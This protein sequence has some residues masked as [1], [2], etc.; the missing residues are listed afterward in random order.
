MFI[1][2]PLVLIFHRLPLRK[3]TEHYRK[4]RSVRGFYTSLWGLFFLWL[5]YSIT[6][7]C[8]IIL[9]GAFFYYLSK[10]STTMKRYFIIN[11]IIFS[12]LFLAHLHR[13]IFM[14]DNPDFY[15]LGFILMVL[16]PRIM[17]FN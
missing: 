1:S 8:A 2:I 10:F 11:G 5:I 14:W 9:L 16:I 7:V 17:Y 4:D 15:G 13:Y 12:V 6:E 3:G